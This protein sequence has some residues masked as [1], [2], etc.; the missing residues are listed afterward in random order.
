MDV[1]VIMSRL[2]IKLGCQKMGMFLISQVDY[3]LKRKFRSLS[4]FLSVGELFHRQTVED[5]SNIRNYAKQ[6]E[7]N[8]YQINILVTTRE[9][10]EG[11]NF[12]KYNWNTGQSKKKQF[13]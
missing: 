4:F 5:R 1:R 8:C 10:T 3:A 9:I 12:Q 13:L 11:N 7:Q 6:D 2:E